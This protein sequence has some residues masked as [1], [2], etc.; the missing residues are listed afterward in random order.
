LQVFLAR[1]AGQD[2]VI[3]GTPSAGRTRA[4]DEGLVGYCVNMLPMRANLAGNPTFEG[5]LARAKRTVAGAIEHQEFPFSLMIDRLRAEIDPGRPP[6]IQVMYAH[7]RSQRLDDRGLAPFVLG[8]AGAQLDLHGFAVDSVELDRGTAL[9]ELTLVTARDG[10]CLRL[11]WES[12]T[13]LFHD[14]TIERM[15]AGFRGMLAAIVDDPTRKIGDLP[16]IDPGERTRMLEWWSSGPAIPPDEPDVVERFEREAAAAPG[17]PALVLGE[18]IV[19]YGELNRRA[20]LIAREL[21]ARGVGPESVVGLFLEGWTLRLAAV[22]GV[23]KA[24]SAYVPLDLD[25]PV[26]RLAAT[27]A[28]SGARMLLTDGPIAHRA[29]SLG[30]DSVIAVDWLLEEPRESDTGNPE[31]R[32]SAENL[33]YVVF[34]SGTTSRPKGVMVSRRA[35]ASLATAWERLYDLRGSTRRHL[36]AAPFAFDVFAGDWV[37]ALTTGGVLV[38]CPREVRLDPAALA[39]H[40][41]RH[42]IDFVELVPALAEALAEALE[43]SGDAAGLPMRVRALGSDS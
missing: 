23:R 2:D 29:A 6:I 22:L 28:N 35:L 32:A 39:H 16:L 1:H 24:G 34:T 12:S 21:I 43:R 11:M 17:A 4:G 15:A 3:V 37:R 19:P 26:E 27:I 7:Q 31:P 25:H 36:Q 8:I 30:A 14:A 20:N 33:A 40:L 42:R 38:A 18:K 5:F 10:D 9:Y 41:R 13:D